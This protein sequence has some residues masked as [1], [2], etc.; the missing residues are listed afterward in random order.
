[1]PTLAL[2]KPAHKYSFYSG[3]PGP[4]AIVHRGGDGAGRK[5]ENSLAAFKSAHDAGIIYGETDVILTEDGKVL[6]FHGS[7]NKWQEKRTG[8]P[9]R[10][11]MQSMTYEQIEDRVK[12]GG[13]RV[14]LFEELLTAFP[15][16]RFFIDPKTPEVVEPLAEVI[17]RHHA[18]NRV[19]IGAFSYKRS[20]KTVQ[21]LGG[22]KDICTCL[23]MLGSHALAAMSM[24]A[25]LE[26]LIEK[27]QATSLQLPYK[28]VNRK[29]IEKAH[30][31]GVHVIVWTPNTKVDIDTSL[32]K[33]VY[34]VM[35]DR[36]A[37]LAGEIL[38]KD[39]DNRS[40][41]HRLFRHFIR[42]RAR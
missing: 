27:S 22:S 11:E 37:L 19:S 15:D 6:A 39:P 7:A 33:G 10:K 21:L 4:I 34:G 41:K 36:T 24:G 17:K 2:K 25:P 9:T 28:F 40:I 8:L 16:M 31:L 32:D 26:N 1:M 38:K 29:M 12:I 35:S 42:R 18:Q 13:E 14:P 20:K 30:E 3:Q 23:G 5:K